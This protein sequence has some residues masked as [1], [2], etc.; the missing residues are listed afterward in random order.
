MINMSVMC[1]LILFDEKVVVCHED[2]HS[3]SFMVHIVMGLKPFIKALY[4]RNQ[5]TTKRSMRQTWASPE[6]VI[7]RS[8]MLF[9]FL[10]KQYKIHAVRACTSVNTKD[11]TNCHAR[12]TSGRVKIK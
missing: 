8:S 12:N 9:A 10:H 4:S 6:S 11:P 3:L 7:G 2:D 5:V 1:L